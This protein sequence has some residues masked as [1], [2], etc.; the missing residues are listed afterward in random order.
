MDGDGK[1]D[2]VVV[3][4]S[5]L[6]GVRSAAARDVSDRQRELAG[7]AGVGGQQPGPLRNLQTRDMNMD[8]KS[9]TVWEMG[10][11]DRRCSDH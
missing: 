5:L 7:P 2:D 6:L 1:I 9:Q 10:K 11:D 8:L 4:F 3:R